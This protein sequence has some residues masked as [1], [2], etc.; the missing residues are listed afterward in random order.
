MD[1]SALAKLLQHA[2]T[3]AVVGLSGA[4]E[5]DSYRVASYLLS[6][7]YDVIPVNPHV[8]N[9]L[10]RKA[11]ARLGDIEQDVDIVDVFRKSDAVDEVAQEAIAIRAKLIW[12]QLGIRNPAAEDR[13][14]DAGLTVIADRCLMVEHRRLLGHVAI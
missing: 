12:L 6:Q 9:V 5:R 3:I 11:V 1:D 7:G 10:G 8:S 2:R 4:P 13:A 14:R